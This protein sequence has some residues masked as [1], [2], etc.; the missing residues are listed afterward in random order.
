MENLSSS[1]EIVAELF[2]LIKLK[3]IAFVYF[4]LDYIASLNLHQW[5]LIKAHHK[6]LSIS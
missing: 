3:L 5:A 6:S 2:S 4:A 1:T